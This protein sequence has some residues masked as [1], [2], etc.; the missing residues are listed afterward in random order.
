MPG[1]IE[2]ISGDAFATISTLGAEPVAWSV[3]GRE[4]LWAGD[5]AFWPRISP[6]LF[7]IVG[8]AREGRIRVGG[9]AYPMPIHGFAPAGRFR[10]AER[11]RGSVRLVLEDGEDTHRHYPFRFRL[12]V[13]YRLEPPILAAEFCVANTG[14]TPLPFALGF[15]P[16]FRW[17]LEG[18][19]RRGHAI[20]FEAAESAAV[21]VITGDGLFSTRTRRAPLEG[22]MLA[23]DEQALAREA[24]CFLGANS[25]W[26]RFVSPDGSAIR[27]TAENFTHWA[28]WGRPGAGFVCME[29]WTGY[30]DPDGFAGEIAEKPSM[31]MLAAGGESLHRV[32]MTYEAAA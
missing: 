3:G 5:P 15:H 29:A 26:L 12:E 6:V 18:D 28:L 27:M 32:E 25:G 21:P 9:K 30:G 17:P 13:A 8:R 23:L 31:R 2:L 11:S 24:L 16:G 19:D 22:R 20:E 4:L 14:D 7:P 1:T 10:A